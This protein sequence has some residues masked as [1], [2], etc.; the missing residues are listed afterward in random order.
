MKI[1]ATGPLNIVASQ[2]SYEL[3]KELADEL[4]SP[5]ESHIDATVR[6]ELYLSKL[7]YL[8]N[9]QQ[10]CFLSVNSQAFKNRQT[11]IESDLEQIKKAIE[12]THQ[13]MRQTILEELEKKLA[14][15]LSQGQR[16]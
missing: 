3:Y 1:M 9:L 7:I 14:G 16:A 4:M 10:Q 13:F 5:I 8:E 15:G 6:Y 2:D 12:C 11:F